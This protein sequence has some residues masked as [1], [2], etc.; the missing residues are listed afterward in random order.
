MSTK[1]VV[2]FQNMVVEVRRAMARDGEKGMMGSMQMDKERE[3]LQQ[4]PHRQ[5]PQ[6]HD[7]LPPRT[8]GHPQCQQILRTTA[9]GR[10]E[11]ID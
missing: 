4:Q 6:L 7:G 2:V 8:R 1:K 3:L 5:Q 10:S 11:S 9:S